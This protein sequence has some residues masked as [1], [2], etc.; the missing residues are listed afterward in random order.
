MPPSRL[1]CSCDPFGII[2]DFEPKNFN[3]VLCRINTIRIADLSQKIRRLVSPD[4]SRPANKLEK[5]TVIEA[6]RATEGNKVKAAKVLGV[7]RATLYRFFE[8]HPDSKH[9]S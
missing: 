9:P 3:A 8:T 4:Q 1:V 2:D 7:G 6:L 5:Q